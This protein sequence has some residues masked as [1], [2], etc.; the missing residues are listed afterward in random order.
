MNIINETRFKSIPKED[1]AFWLDILKKDVI[2]HNT[3]KIHA[4]YREQQQ[5]RSSNKFK[6]I[7]Q[8]WFVLRNI[9]GVKPIV[10]SYFM[11]IF[12]FKGFFKYLK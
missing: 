6:M 12:L 2:A 9:Q 5:S 8:Q 10:A 1:Y 7:S 11:L 3:G 4:L